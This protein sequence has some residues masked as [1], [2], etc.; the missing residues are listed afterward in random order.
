MKPV[1]P[2]V[3]PLFTVTELVPV[4]VPFVLQRRTARAVVHRRDTGVGCWPRRCEC[5]GAHLGNDRGS[6]GNDSG[7]VPQKVVNEILPP[8]T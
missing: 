2:S 5:A 4:P 6:R 1:P 7:F 3:P 8:I